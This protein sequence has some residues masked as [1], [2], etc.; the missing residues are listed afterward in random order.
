M[1]IRFEHSDNDFE[2]FDEIKGGVV[3]KKN[4]IPKPLK[5]GLVEAKEKGDV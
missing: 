1:P 2:F 3:P 4:Y 5:K